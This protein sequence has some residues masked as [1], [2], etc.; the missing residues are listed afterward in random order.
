MFETDGPDKVYE[1]FFFDIPMIYAQGPHG[2]AFMEALQVQKN[3]SLYDKTGIQLLVRNHWKFW[4]KRNYMFIILPW[5]L[6]LIVFTLWS[7]I[8][9][10][11]KAN[12]DEGF[13]FALELISLV[14]ASYFLVVRLVSLFSLRSIDLFFEDVAGITINIISPTLIIACQVQ[15]WKA[16]FEASEDAKNAID[17]GL[18]ELMAWTS[19]I[20]WFNFLIALRSIEIFSPVISMILNSFQA[21]WPYM[22]VL[23]IG[24]MAFADAF[25]SIQQIY[26]IKTAESEEPEVPPFDKNKEVETLWDWKDKWFGEYITFW[27]KQFMVA[28]AG[29]SGDEIAVMTDTQ[30]LLLL[31]CIFF[32]MFIL[33]N[34]MLAVVGQIFAEDY[35]SQNQKRYSLIVDQIC[36]LQR[37]F[38]VKN[39]ASRYGF[40]FMAKERT[41]VEYRNETT[42]E[43]VSN[44]AELKQ[45][46]TEKD[47]LIMS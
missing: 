36:M 21:I 16:H 12:A 33:S 5:V 3:P 26:Y 47:D 13:R 40:L 20:M 19:F 41:E 38:P 24:V 44:F 15:H 1:Y 7:S 42:R 29:A 32:N 11:N 25:Q 6:Q 2:Q 22:I 30:W 37:S 10:P 39:Q 23:F 35:E 9:L 4:R 27:K 28:T 14:I 31:V 17:E 8:L 43:M 46:I 18:W 34:L 45:I